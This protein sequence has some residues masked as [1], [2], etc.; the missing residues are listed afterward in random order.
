MNQSENIQVISLHNIQ[1]KDLFWK[2]ALE[3]VRKNMIPYQWSALHDK[4][5]DAP[6]SHC[7]ENFRIATK[8][9][10]KGCESLQPSET[11]YGHVFQDSDLYKWIEAVAY[12]LCWHPDENLETMA[13][14]AIELIKGAQFSDGYI[15]TYYTITGM[16][17]RFTNLKDNHEL[18]CFG[19]LIEA[20]VAYHQTTGKD[21]FLNIASHC[22]DCINHHIG[23]QEGKIHG[24]PGHP[25]LEMALVRLYEETKQSEYLKMAEYFVNER[26]TAPLFFEQETS[27]N[28]NTFKWE[29][30]AFQ[31][32]YYQ[33]GIP[34]REQ[35]IAEGHAVRALYLYS[36]MA[37]VAR[38]LNDRELDAVCLELWNN[39]VEKQM[40]ITGAIGQSAY[41]ES[42]SCDYDLPNDLIYGESCA[43]VAMVFFAQRM[44]KG[45]PNS[46]FADVL[47]LELYNTVLAGTA[48]DG[49]SF[50]YVN[51]LEVVPELCEKVE[52][53]RHV[54]VV[55]Q[56]WFGCACCPPNLARLIAS[57]GTYIHTVQD[58]SLYTHLFISSQ[59]EVIFN[60]EQVSVHITGNYPWEGIIHIS[61]YT[62]API[63]FTY[64]IRKPSFSETMTVLING[65]PVESITYKDGYAKLER[66]WQDGDEITCILDVV[67][68]I[69]EANPKVREDIGKVAVMRGPLVYCLEQVDNGGDL[70]LVELPTSA[71]FTETYEENLLD[72]VLTLTCEGKKISPAG[73]TQKSLYRPYTDSAKE[74]VSLTWIPYYAWDNRTP[75]EMRVWLRKLEE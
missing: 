29:N 65:N 39:V 27:R 48:L 1:V 20:A 49:K 23:P 61:L 54:K 40:Y 57:V 42:F 75:G 14:E 69:I 44:L 51:P 15:N 38:L 70:H 9:K 71:K 34:I 47:E 36:G 10:E 50:F 74:L 18:Y 13:D 55:R 58:L 56:K 16:E 30:S 17:K 31:Y 53:Y 32:Q 6:S 25:I 59:A 28:A 11:H 7:I 73:W 46:Y 35:H 66:V 43:S 64:Y 37:D 4:V 45:H 60:K 12:S 3:N 41:G 62:Q 67:P 68:R 24:Y 5:K 26:G 8:V 22:A 2:G 52:S 19:H 63:A 33:A 21:T 72:G